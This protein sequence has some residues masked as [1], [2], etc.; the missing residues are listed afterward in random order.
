MD[1]QDEG[2]V[3]LKREADVLRAANER[4]R[5]KA[6]TDKEWIDGCHRAL[7]EKDAQLDE[8]RHVV[9]SGIPIDRED[10]LAAWRRLEAACQI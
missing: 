5:V 8:V 2:Y 1:E 3:R 9:R 4:L 7:K 6:I 10:A